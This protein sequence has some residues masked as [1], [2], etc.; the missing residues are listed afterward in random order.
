MV[1]QAIDA[2]S[3][4]IIESFHIQTRKRGGASSTETQRRMSQALYN[5]EVEENML[6]E[7]SEDEG[8]A[9]KVQVNRKGEELSEV[10]SEEM[11]ELRDVVKEAVDDALW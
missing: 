3:A 7:M 10:V 8:S 6:G 11:V 2:V 9:E 1:H 4:D 5:Q